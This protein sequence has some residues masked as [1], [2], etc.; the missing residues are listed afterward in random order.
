MLLFEFSRPSQ[1]TKMQKESFFRLI[2]AVKITLPES[3]PIF[4]SLSL[5]P[6]FM[7]LLNLQPAV[8]IFTKYGR[9]LQQN[10]LDK[11]PWA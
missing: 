11:L 9:S 1:N 10:I 8:S 2:I 3:R 5:L 7:S 4:F 6:H